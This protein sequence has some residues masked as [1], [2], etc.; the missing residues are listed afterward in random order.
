MGADF[1]G[2]RLGAF[3]VR[4]GASYSYDSIDTSRSIEKKKQAVRCYHA[5][6]HEH[7]LDSLAQR[8][9]Q[10][11]MEKAAGHSCEFAEELK[12]ITPRHLHAKPGTWKF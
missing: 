11:A 8:V 5:Q 7:E 3:N 12:V 2:G 1:A 9:E 6:F 4:G 10:Y